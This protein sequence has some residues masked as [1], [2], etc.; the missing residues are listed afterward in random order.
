MKSSFS[1]LF[2]VLFLSAHAAPLTRDLSQGLAYHR[3][4]TVPA[5]L[6]T[7]EADRKQPCVLDLRYAEGDTAA[8]TALLAWLKFHAA[9]RTPVF[10]LVN[11]DTSAALLAPVADRLPF[12]GL[13]VIGSASP[14]LTPDL[15]LKIASVDERRAYGALAAGTPVESL[16]NDTPE[17][18]RND[19]AR[20]AQDHHGQPDPARTPA[21]DGTEDAPA[22]EK[23]VPPKAPAPLIDSAL[24]RAVQLHRSLKALKKI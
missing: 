18:T 22:T 16:L 8:G 20:L 17:K 4:A 13:I 15:E 23:P 2:L 1:F 19:E 9:V 3:A 24:Q 11:A 12:A 6:P 5:D 7:G 21:D 14:G 10:L